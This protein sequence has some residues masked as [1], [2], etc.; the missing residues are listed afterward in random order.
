MPEITLAQALATAIAHHQAGRLAD[1]ERIYRQILAT[2]S[3]SRRGAALA[4]SPGRASRRRACG[5]RPDRPGDHHRSRAP[6][7]ITTTWASRTA[8]RDNRN[9]RSPA[10]S[11]RS[12]LRP[13]HA[14][15]HSNLGNA[16]W[17]LGRLDEAIDAC[18]RA[19]ALRPDYPEAHNNLGNA[20]KDAGR[21][22]EAIAAFDRAIALRPDY[23]EAHNNLGC[24]RLAQGDHDAA[25]AAFDRATAL[26]PD[27]AEAHFNLGNALQG[28]GRCDEAID[29]YRRAIALR[30]DHAGPHGNLG[31]TLKGQ[32]RLDEAIAAYR[33]A[34]ALRPDDPEVHSNL[35]NA[36]WAAGR[37]DEAIAAC[38]RAIEL[39]PDL[40]EA[41]SN[42]GNALWAA[43]RLDEAIAACRRAIELRPDLAEAHNNLG[44]ALWASGQHD[45]A[46]AAFG[47]AIALEPDHA[48]AHNNLGSALRNAG[49]LDEAIAALGR[50]IA[51]RPDYAEAHNNL[52]GARLAQGDL[53]EATRG[54]P[55]GTGAAAGR[56]RRPLELAV[57]RSSTRAGRPW[58]AWPAPTP[59]GTSS[60][61]RAHRASQKPWDGDRD[62]ERPLRL[63]FLSP[64]LRRHPVGY[65]LVRVLENLDR[66]AFEVIC[67]HNRADGDDYTHRLAAASDHWH[68]VAGL[69]DERLAAQIRGDRID[70][71]FD[72]SGHTSGHRLLV[73]ARRP[74][75][76]QITWIGYV[77][78]TGLA[79]IDY[80][81]ADRFH[82]PPGAE[83]HYREKVLRMPDGYVCF[84]PP[85]EAPAG[86][87]LAGAGAG[88]LHVWQLQQRPQA[89]GRGHRALGPDRRPRAR[90]TAL[91]RLAGPGQRGR[92]GA[93]R[94]C[95]RRRRRRS[96]PARAPRL[97]RPARPARRL[98]PG[99][100]GARS[101]SL[102]GRQ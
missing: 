75:P 100:P 44:N 101:V 76:I 47:R 46:I 19:I 49:R 74:A 8:E 39:K 4:R 60:T 50:A 22:D 92:T 98:Q 81:I 25:I 59:S 27:L 68:E 80:L 102:L 7:P 1:A 41:H 57:V 10:S 85:A 73:F 79:A 38:R 96:D 30:P 18:R 48:D 9:G 43:G 31:N 5:D 20:L 89:L 33:R 53:E 23:A 35:G 15:A 16:L 64:D 12:R 88:A 28:A 51:L 78:T 56:R 62:P 70:I 45:E 13:D 91:A 99:R 3:R 32:G 93:D 11:A 84:D 55:S 82:V 77:G 6:L 87:S 17:E 24:T 71:L 2:R 65:F 21:L 97:P 61:P 54:L 26:R 36:L 83:T 40:A 34:I 37:L 69:A 67:Y 94:F 72:L 58:P 52:A 42:L 66:R 86:R 14:Q 90:F 63:G 95:V 29:A